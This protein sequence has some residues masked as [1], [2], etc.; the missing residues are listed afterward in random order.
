MASGIYGIV[1]IIATATFLLI[2]IEQF[3]RR[4]SLIG[5]SSLASSSF[6][7]CLPISVGAF[8]MGTFFFIL[9]ALIRTHPPHPDASHTS[10]ASIAMAVM[11][12][13]YGMD[14]HVDVFF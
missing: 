13:L 6:E 5:A 4:K 3:G 8:L 9:G 2:G 12:Y 7:V 14:F 11:I 1:K 10:G